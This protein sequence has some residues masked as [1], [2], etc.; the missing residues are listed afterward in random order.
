M[1]DSEVL[2]R[3]NGTLRITGDF[4]IQDAEG[5]TFDTTGRTVISLFRRGAS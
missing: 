3:N 2:C 5:D 1:P 4:V